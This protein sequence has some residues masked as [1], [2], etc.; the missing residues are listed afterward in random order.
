MLQ[1]AAAFAPSFLGGE[2]TPDGGAHSEVGPKPKLSPRGSPTKE[3]EQKS[4][5]ASAQTMD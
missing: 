1:S 5:H 3:E 2:Q 4:L